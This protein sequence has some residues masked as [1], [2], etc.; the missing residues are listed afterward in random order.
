MTEIK[1][2]VVWEKDKRKGLKSLRKFIG[3]MNMFT[4][5]IVVMV[6][7]IYTYF[8]FINLWSSRCGTVVNES[9]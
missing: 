3:V 9:N 8:K 5:L 7:C 6:S 4:I 2:V 1:P